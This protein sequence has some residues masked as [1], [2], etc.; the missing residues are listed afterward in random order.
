MAVAAVRAFF[1][2]SGAALRARQEKEVV[3]NEECILRALGTL[4]ASESCL[5]GMRIR[6]KQH[7]YIHRFADLAFI[8]YKRLIAMNWK[9]SRVLEL[10][11]WRATTLRWAG[12]ETRVLQ[13]L[14]DNGQAR[15]GYD[16]WE[17]LVTKLEIKNDERLP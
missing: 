8:M 3:K 7:I 1:H 13:A 10:H 4:G 16:T 6:A 14:R 9:A 5:L 11:K 2:L 17:E 15:T 12:T